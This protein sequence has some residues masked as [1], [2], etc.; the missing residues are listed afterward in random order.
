M[1]TI[2]RFLSK[3]IV[4]DSGC[5]EWQGFI[6]KDGYCV[7][8]VNGKKT[9]IHRFIYEYYYGFIDP[10]L[11][12]H[13]NCYNRNCGNPS[14]LIQMTLR[15]NILDG[16]N[17]AAINARKTHCKHGHEFTEGNTYRYPDGRRLCKICNII[18]TKTYW[19]KRASDR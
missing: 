3:I 17:L 6:R 1:L 9:L 19:L 13:H 12:I 18:N 16:D 11:T 15:D 7:L 10:K 4:T 14:H 8:R 5:W 2:H